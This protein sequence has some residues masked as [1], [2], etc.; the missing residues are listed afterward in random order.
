MSGLD[1]D[2]SSKMLKILSVIIGLVYNLD[3]EVIVEGIEIEI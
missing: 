3:L 1:L 2:I